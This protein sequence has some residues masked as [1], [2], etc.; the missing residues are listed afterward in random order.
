MRIKNSITATI[1]RNLMAS[2]L[3]AL[4]GTGSLFAAFN[5]TGT[6]TV[7][8]TVANEA[9]I[10]IDT[11]TTNLT[12]TGAIFNDYT[13]TTNL[14]YKIRTSQGT[15]SGSVTL[16]V[17]SDFAPGGGPS[18]ATPPSGG[19]ALSYTCTVSAPASACSGSQTSATSAATPV[20]TFGADARSA[21][22]GNSGTV[23]WNLTND[24]VYQT[25]SY[26][27]TVTFTISST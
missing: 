21:K 17:T 15:G 2:A 26:S 19:D 5:T 11:P 22:A 8:V 12:T 3:L 6:T 4:L 10:Q 24:P 14:T 9:A 25:G 27:G 1:L 13:G 20:A 7:S 23:N 18:V 16:Q